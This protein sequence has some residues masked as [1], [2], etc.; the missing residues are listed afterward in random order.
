MTI[1]E[2]AEFCQIPVRGMSERYKEMGV[3]YVKL[4]RLV[5]FRSEDIESWLASL[6]VKPQ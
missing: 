3:P 4:G 2:L 5:R 1:E 6:T